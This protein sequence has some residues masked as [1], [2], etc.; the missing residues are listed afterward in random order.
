M[1]YEPQPAITQ[2][3]ISGNKIASVGTRLLFSNGLLALSIMVMSFIQWRAL[4][5]QHDSSIRIFTLSKAQQSNQTADIMHDSI[6]AH[7]PGC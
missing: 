7:M 4:E 2:S 1:A 5:A 6:R 3:R